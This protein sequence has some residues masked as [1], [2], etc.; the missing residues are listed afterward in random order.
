[1]TST[2]FGVKRTWGPYRFEQSIGA[3][4]L[5]EHLEV[6]DVESSRKHAATVSYGL[7]LRRLDN[8]LLPNKGYLFNLQFTSAPFESLSEGTFLRSYAKTQIYYPLTKST[9]LMTRIEVGAVSGANSAPATYLFRAGGDQSVRG[10]AFQSLGV[11]EGDAVVGGRYLLTGS[12]EL[13]QWLNSQWGV[14][15]FTDFGNAADEID[16]ITPV[17]GYGL[18]GRWKS[19]LGPV[20]ADIAY[21][22]DTGDYRLHF[23]L[24]VNF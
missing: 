9:Q 8:D 19:P 21:G 23:N 7:T 24:G 6:E 12:V 10:Y 16:K 15:L 22:Q 4:Y 3:N 2:N 13:V 1:L 20:G 5:L 14:A 11:A 18:G 17:Y